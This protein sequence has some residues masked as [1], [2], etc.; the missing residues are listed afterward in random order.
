MKQQL[1]LG[2]LDLQLFDEVSGEGQIASSGESSVGTMTETTSS[3]GERAQNEPMQDAAATM[4][5][6]EPEA[7]DRE[8]A[9]ERLISKE[10]KDIFGKRVQDII[11]KRFKES[12]QLEQQFEQIQPVLSMLSDYFETE[13]G[14]VQGLLNAIDHQ[15]ELFEA[16]ADTEEDEMAMEFDDDEDEY[17]GYDETEDEEPVSVGEYIAQQLHELE[18]SERE[19]MARQEA[20]EFARAKAISEFTFK[21]WLQQAEGVKQI[22]PTFDLAT[23][24]KNPQFVAL[25]KSN[26]DVRSAYEVTHR[27]EIIGSAMHYTAQQVA[28]KVTD[29]IR[30]KSSRPIENG[31][32]SR[33]GHVTKQNVK[34]L[35]REQREEISRRVS[36]GERVTF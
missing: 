21:S 3:S 12:K 28:K 31:L 23:E 13:D 34:N 26:V 14:D 17:D 15:A 29:N 25:L 6:D 10:Y 24:F 2:K 36:R 30:Y 18:E 5:P 4:T 19:T 9:F 16:D 32:Q 1:E 11:N 33:S 22:Y 7:Q 8:Q 35:T 20:E 27:D